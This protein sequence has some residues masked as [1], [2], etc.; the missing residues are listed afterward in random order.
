MEFYG[1][2]GQGGSRP[3]SPQRSHGGTDLAISGRGV[4]SFLAE[5]LPTTVLRFWPPPPQA[6]VACFLEAGYEVTF[7]E[8][9]GPILIAGLAKEGGWA[10]PFL[11]W[12]VMFFCL[13]AII[14]DCKSM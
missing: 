3:S 1:E 5:S 11:H 14:V 12:G 6:H 8:A 2:W 9:D 13:T 4:C 10:E 7:L